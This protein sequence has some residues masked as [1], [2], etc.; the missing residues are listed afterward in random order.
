MD[1]IWLFFLVYHLLVP[2][3]CQSVSEQHLGMAK[4]T[5]TA[6][7]QIA[8]PYGPGGV[9]FKVPWALIPALQFVKWIHL[10]L[11]NAETFYQLGLA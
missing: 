1:L 5:L 9:D 4:A 8:A 10:N 6:L 7:G 3:H 2:I 11:Q